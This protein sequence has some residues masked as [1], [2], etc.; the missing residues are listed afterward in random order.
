MSLTG[1]S[2]FSAHCAADL[3]P[4]AAAKSYEHPKETLRKFMRISGRIHGAAMSLQTKHIYEF[5]H[6]RLDAAEHLLLRDG[7]AVPLTPKAFDLLLAL[8]ERH[9]HLLEKEELLKKVWPDTFVEEA[10]LASNISLVRK[11][12][13]DG[14]N[15]HRYI[16]T[17]PKRGYRFVASV[18]EVEAESRRPSA[19]SLPGLEGSVNESGSAA[20]SDEGAS[21][22]IALKVK[23]LTGVIMRRPKALILALAMIVPVGAAIVY[24]T[25]LIR[26][27]SQLDHAP[28]T[29]ARVTYDR[30]LQSEPTW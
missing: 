11:A 25:F 14:E 24:A 4:G 5:G 9:G 17:A 30:G 10:N 15:G 23:S 16:E 22:N 2:L 26:Q 29:L 12:L 6:F 27:R 18:Q 19:A 3:T 20:D 7:E 13:G 21:A 8:V 1:F 28:R